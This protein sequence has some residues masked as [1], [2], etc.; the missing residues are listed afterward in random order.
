ML[1]DE[2]KVGWLEH[3]DRWAGEQCD[4]R[5]L[6]LL[7]DGV[8]I[9]GLWRRFSSVLGANAVSL[10]FETLPGCSEDV[11]DASPILLRYYP[12]NHAL[13]MLLNMCSGWPMVS[14]LATSES[15]KLLA[16]R[17][18]AWC[19]VEND[20][21]RFNFRYP[22]TRRL[23]EIFSVLT[24][25]QRAELAG[26]ATGWRF[27]DRTGRWNSLQMSGV[28]LPVRDRPQK[29]DDV[30]FGHMVSASDADEA[31]AQLNYRGFQTSG[32]PSQYHA[33]VTQALA[34]AAVQKLESD[35]HLDWCMACVAEGGYAD[36]EKILFALGQ[37]RVREQK[38]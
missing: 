35:R 14:A 7:I 21:Q 2:F 27:I 3:L 37:W 24:S 17:L 16:E 1:I 38:E 8:F 18:A 13:Q 23:P 15:L 4:G 11:K 34:A 30:Q 20:G 26:P 29:L 36:D 22:D 5:H 9:P 6:Y 32:N 31:I 12:G 28:D 25:Q 19:I 33:I 10:L